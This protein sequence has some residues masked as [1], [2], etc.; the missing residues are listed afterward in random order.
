MKIIIFSLIFTLTSPLWAKPL[1]VE[2][3]ANLPDVSNLS[4]S[5]DGKKTSSV[6]R[7]DADKTQG[8]AVEVVDLATGEKKYVLYSDNQKYIFHW[9]RWKDNQTLL[10]GAFFPSERDTWVGAGQARFKTRD[11]RLTIVNIE[12]GEITTP[13][14]KAFLKKYQ[15][16][17]PNMDDVIDVLP[18]DPDHILMVFPTNQGY[19]GVFKVNIRNQT[20]RLIQRSMDWVGGWM[21]DRQHRV[22]VG[23]YYRYKD[24][25][26]K[27]L[28]HNLADDKWLELWPHTVFSEESVDPLGFGLDPNVLYIRA[29]HEGRL[30]VFKV[31]LTDKELKRELVMAD[32]IYDINGS[33]VYSPLTGSVVGITHSQDGGF[34]FFDPEAKA[35][36]ASIDRALPKTKNYIVSMSDDTKKYVVFA[37][38]D[39]DSGTYYVGQREPA[40]LD[41]AAYRYKNL[42]PEL[43][44][45]VKRYDYKARDG[46]NIEAYLALPKNSAAKNLPTIVFPH[47]GP[48]ARDSDSFDYWTQYFANKGYAVL[49][50]NFRGSAGQGLE[51]R[52]AGLK[53]WGME[54]QDDIEDGA[55]KLIADGIADTKSICIVGASYGGYAALMGAV[56]TPDFYRCSISVAGV[57]NVFD[58]VKDNRMFWSGYNVIDEMIGNDNK[59][60]RV[61][62]PVN[63]ADKIK[64]PVLLIHG[65]SDRQV[66]IKHSKQ[67]HD[68]LEKAGKDVTY[69]ELANEDHYLTNND[70]RVATFRAMDAFLDKHLPVSK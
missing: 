23:Y 21:T 38:N 48:I 69:V 1:P 60:L 55:R 44:V 8:M 54:M 5:P 51:F 35:L 61:I 19:A 68:A 70:N 39:V 7:I 50:M 33:L 62:S 41:A 42:P 43:M 11:T 25:L 52:N 30:A 67:M 14:S 24:G 18:N 2:Y 29:Y 9:V 15:I 46:L 36:Q 66:D 20:S 63:H 3:F 22:R 53:N 26:K 56:K 57:S 16:L 4:L 6:V 31:N 47:G 17:P 40:K 34:T 12:S 13:F 37:A 49:Q 10:V 27:T 58:L 65:D 64:I 32:P 59:Q 45:P 28:V